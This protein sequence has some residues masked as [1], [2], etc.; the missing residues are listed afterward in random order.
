MIGIK[1][2]KPED[3]LQIWDQIRTSYGNDLV[4]S[5]AYN[6]VEPLL[7]ERGLLNDLPP[8]VGLS[9]QEIEERLFK[10]AV[11]LAIDGNYSQA[12]P[13]LEEYLRQ[14]ENGNHIGEANFYLAN[15]LNDAEDYSGALLSYEKVLSLPPSEFTEASALG[16]ATL[17]WN[18]DDYPR[19]LDHYR[20]LGE[21]TTLQSNRLEA[22]IGSMRC[23]YLLDKPEE[24]LGF[25]NEVYNDKST[26]ESIKR[27]AALWLG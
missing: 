18:G 3:V 9:G 10:A 21:V 4:A 24:A 11:N 16:A 2:D 26:P 6:I 22:S 27:T 20:L 19:A 12:L 8:A 13:R 15:C 14:Y 5:D 7:I 25:A 17:S 23:Y 1:Q